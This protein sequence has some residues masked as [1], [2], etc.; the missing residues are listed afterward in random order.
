MG[1]LSGFLGDMEP[2]Y[3]L[4]S[5]AVARWRALGDTRGLAFALF[6]QGIP[7]LFRV[8]ADEA[9]AVLREARQCFADL[10]DD[11]GVALATVYEGVARAFFAGDEDRRSTC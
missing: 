11:W 1:R 3:L 6:Y 5:Q 4:G 8:G 9:A 10:D 2:A 7:T